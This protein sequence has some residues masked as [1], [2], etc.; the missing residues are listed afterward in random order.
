MDTLQEIEEKQRDEH[1]QIREDAEL[2]GSLMAHKGWGRYMALVETIA[3]NYHAAVMK[4]LDSALEVT[5]MEFAKGVL[6]GLTLATAL[7]QMKI[8]EA[9]EVRRGDD[10]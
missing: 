3:Q 8:R 10:E 7:P 2:F 5:K 6:S 4:P 1:R 9:H